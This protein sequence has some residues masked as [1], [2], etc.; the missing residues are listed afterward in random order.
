MSKLPNT[1]IFKILIIIIIINNKGNQ[2]NNV[3]YALNNLKNNMSI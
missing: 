3:S 2:E 1:D